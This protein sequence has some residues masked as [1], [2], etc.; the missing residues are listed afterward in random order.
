MKHLK[1]TAIALTLVCGIGF[2]F[3]VLNGKTKTIAYVNIESVYNEFPL[4]KELEKKL[5][6]IQVINQAQLDSIKLNIQLIRVQVEQDKNPET[7][8]KAEALQRMYFRKEQEINERNAV[9]AKQ[10]TDQIWQQIGQY[11]KDYGET[12]PYDVILSDDENRRNVL[13][14]NASTD[15]TAEVKT[16]I[17]NRYNGNSK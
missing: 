13:Y 15:I 7:I 11:V 12:H 8:A 1:T 14:A 3:Y 17:N 16:Y 6:R 2:G 5:D 10:F 9:A 4:K